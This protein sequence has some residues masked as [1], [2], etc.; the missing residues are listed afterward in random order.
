MTNPIAR[1]RDMLLQFD[2]EVLEASRGE[3]AIQLTQLQRP[4]LILTDIVMPGMTG[5][6]L[7]GHLRP[8]PGCKRGRR[9]SQAA[10]GSRWYP[11]PVGFVCCHSPV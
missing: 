7:I 8:I 5:L 6:E 2:F 3:E 4:D 10:P 1:L 11:H 9:P